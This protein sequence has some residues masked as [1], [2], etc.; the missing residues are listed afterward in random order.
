MAK[1]PSKRKLI[2][3]LLICIVVGLITSVGVAWIAAISF[4]IPSQKQQWSWYF[5]GQSGS[6]WSWRQLQGNTWE[7]IVSR[8]V[9]LYPENFLEVK[10][11]PHWSRVHQLIDSETYPSNHSV[12]EEAYGWPLNCMLSVR[13]SIPSTL[14]VVNGIPITTTVVRVFEPNMLPTHPIWRGLLVN[15]SLYALSTWFVIFGRILLRNSIR[16]KRGLCI[17]CRYNVRELPVC[18]ECGS[19]VCTK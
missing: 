11:G 5:T 14:L 15:T 19:E 6:V 8:P 7:A 2:T 18:P 17:H 16:R 12:L 13:K 10:K 3:R 9:Y 4:D 1:P